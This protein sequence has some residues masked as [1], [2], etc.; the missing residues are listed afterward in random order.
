MGRI[1]YTL[2]IDI[3]FVSFVVFLIAGCSVIPNN[4][5]ADQEFN[6]SRAYLDVIYQESLG[7]RIPGAEGHRKIIEWISA[8]LTKNDWR[9]ELQ[10]TS[11]NGKEITN[12]V[13]IRDD[14]DDYILLGAHYDTRIFADRDPNPT[15]QNQPVPGAND[16]GSGVAVLLEIARVLPEDIKKPVRLV[17]FDAEDNG[18][19]EDWAW[20]MGSRA[21]VEN[22]E[23]LPEIAVIVDMVGDAELNIYYEHNSDPYLMERIWN[24][25]AQ[26]GYGEYFIKEYRHSILDDHTPFV[27]AGVPAVDIIDLDYTY[28]HTIADTADKVSEDSLE[29][30][31]NTVISWLMSIQ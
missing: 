28:W 21:F 7:P 24:Q 11:Y 18:G 13:A 8:E 17:F 16:G 23:N 25:A 20:I 29:A 27:E 19:I 31:G 14:G 3:I 26:L 22:Y 4:K 30:V 12:I 1:R 6:S 9:V 5:A 15:S 10:E 2:L